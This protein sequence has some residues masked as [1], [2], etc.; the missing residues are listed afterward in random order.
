VLVSTLFVGNR[1]I[2]AILD[3]LLKVDEIT[4]AL[5]A[6]SIER[7]ATEH[8]VKVFRIRFVAREVFAFVVFKIFA[9]VFHD[10]SSNTERITSV[11]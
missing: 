8:T 7:T 1:A 11:Y 9:V 5:I 6:E 2:G 3:T 10:N 4:A